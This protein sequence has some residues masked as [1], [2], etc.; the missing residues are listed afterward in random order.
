MAELVARVRAALRR[1]SRVEAVLEAG[2]VRLDLNR[3]IACV[4]GAPYR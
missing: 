4:A 3:H 1:G 2:L